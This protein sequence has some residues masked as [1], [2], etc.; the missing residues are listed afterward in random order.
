MVAKVSSTASKVSRLVLLFTEV[1]GQGGRGAFAM[2]LSMEPGTSLSPTESEAHV[3]G[4][5]EAMPKDRIWLGRQ[6]GSAGTM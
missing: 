2:S 3:L 6:L 1:G 5:V 4:L